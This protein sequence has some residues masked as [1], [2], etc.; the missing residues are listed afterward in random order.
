MRELIRP[1]DIQTA[2]TAQYR[3]VGSGAIILTHDNKFLLQQRGND[4]HSFAGRLSTFGGRAEMHETPLQT[5]SRELN[6][7]LG[8]VVTDAIFLGAYTEKAT[9]YTELCH[10]FFWHDRRRTITGCY[11]GEPAYFDTVDDILK[12]PNLMDDVPWLL[13]I[14]RDRGLL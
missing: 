9:D 14:C 6:E 4:W 13:G 2:D 5:I 7:E 10:G 12:E 1:V 8:A 11:E 3:C